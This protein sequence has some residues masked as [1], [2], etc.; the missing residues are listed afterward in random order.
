[1]RSPRLPDRIDGAVLDALTVEVDVLSA[2]RPVDRTEFARAVAVGLTGVTYSRGQA[3]TAPAAEPHRISPAMVLP[4]AA[5]VLGLDAEQ[6]RRGAMSRYPLTSQ[7]ASLAPRLAVFTTRHYVG[8][9]DGVVVE[10]YRGKDMA[11]RPEVDARALSAA[12]EEVAA[13]LVRHQAPDG[14][15]STPDGPAPLDEHLYAAWV[16]AGLA[17]RTDKDLFADS[18][19]AARNCA[20]RSVQRTGDRVMVRTDDPG[21]ALAAT[22]LLVLAMQSAA[23]DPKVRALRDELC[24]GLLDELASPLAS[25]R[26]VRF[27]AGRYLA[28]LALAS[29]P[30]RAADAAAARQATEKFAPVDFTAH[31]WACRAGLAP[32]KSPAPDGSYWSQRGSEAPPDEAGGIAPAGGPVST[33]QTA[34]TAVCLARATD[35]SPASAKRRQQQTAARWFCHRMMYRPYEAYFSAEPEKWVGGLRAAP[36]AAAVSVEACAAAIEAF[37]AP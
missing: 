25:S 33:V 13:F 23:S 12:S 31:L 2:D 17:R 32:G 27:S 4:S 10:L 22:A 1:M 7:N 9:P 19:A 14:R 34:L 26:P 3:T 16:L 11:R 29:V 24:R 28:L 21:R 30:D 37:T 8:F 6:M 18:A 5:Y 15:Y 35:E 36:E 20:L